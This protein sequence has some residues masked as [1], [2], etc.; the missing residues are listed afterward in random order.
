[1]TSRNLD[2]ALQEE[3]SE[4]MGAL[5]AA[6]NDAK[7]AKAAEQEAQTQEKLRIKAEKA[8]KRAAR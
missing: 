3:E 4:V 1:M 7:A 5:Q 8:A 6:L 2:N